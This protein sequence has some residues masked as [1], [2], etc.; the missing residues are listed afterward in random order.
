M[1]L[2]NQLSDEKFVVLSRSQCGEQS[3]KCLWIRKLDKNI[4]EFQAS[5]ESGKKLTSSVLCGDDEFHNSQWLTQSSKKSL[6]IRVSKSYLFKFHRNWKRRS[7]DSV[8]NQ[9]Q[10]LR[11]ASG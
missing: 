7:E 8:S 3:Y 6:G 11:P 4:L 5:L 9:W 1:T 2:V 10:I